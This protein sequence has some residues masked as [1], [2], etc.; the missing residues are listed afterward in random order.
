MKYIIFL[1]SFLFLGCTAISQK[2]LI[3]DA[4]FIVRTVDINDEDFSDLQ[5]LRQYIG[6]TRIAMLG[7]STHSDGTTLHARTRL[8][9]FLHQEMGF[10]VVAIEAGFFDAFH[11]NTQLQDETISLRDAKDRL[12]RGGWDMAGGSAE[13]FG[14]MR[15]S[16]K[17]ERPLHLAGFDRSRPPYGIK[18]Y[19]TLLDDV[20]SEYPELK[21]SPKES[22]MMDTVINAIAGYLGNKY[23]SKLTSKDY[24]KAGYLIYGLI[25]KIGE[26]NGWKKPN[27]LP[28]EKELLTLGLKSLYFD[29]QLAQLPAGGL[30]WNELRDKFMAD[31]FTWLLEYLYPNKK[32][33]VWAATGHL[34][35]RN[36]EMEHTYAGYFNYQTKP[37][38][39][40]DYLEHYGYDTYL[41]G[42]TNYDGQRGSIYSTDFEYHEE[43]TQ[44]NDLTPAPEDTYEAI[45]HQYGHPYLFTD[46]K[47]Q[48]KDSWLKGK[49]KTYIYQSEFEGELH[50]MFD[51]FFFIDKMEPIKYSK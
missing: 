12:M 4:T 25:E 44:V 6:D 39:M 26:K 2:K 47:N 15:K 43:W 24:E 21:F 28:D 32:I 38:Q 27:T 50:R 48:P 19:L 29:I 36:F 16:W 1:T 9:K 46:I 35:K 45:A 17:T 22:T 49:I 33:I 40:G 13:I 20:F 14:Y 30:A 7:E 42:F 23:I 31:R 10:D 51:G 11:C 34:M 41:I 37:L 5:S 18:H 8:T 3:N